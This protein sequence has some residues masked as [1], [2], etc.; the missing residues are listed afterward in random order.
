VIACNIS[1]VPLTAQFEAFVL[2][3]EQKE[4]DAKK[5]P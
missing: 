1:K 5:S 4:I 2:C 3:T